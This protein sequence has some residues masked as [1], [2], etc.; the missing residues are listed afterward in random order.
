MKTFLTF[1]IVALGLELLVPI[2]LMAQTRTPWQM[3]YGAPLQYLGFESASYGDSTEYIFESIPPAQDSGWGPA[4][5][6]DVIKLKEISAECFIVD[7]IYHC[8]KVVDYTY[9]QTFVSYPSNM[10]LTKFTIRLYGLDD[11]CRVSVYNS[12]Y[13]NGYAIPGTFVKLGDGGNKFSLLAYANPC[14]ENRFVITHVDDCCGGVVLDTAFIDIAGQFIPSNIL[15]LTSTPAFCSSQDSSGTATVTS[16]AQGPF[17]YLW[18]TNPPQTTATA[19]NL[20]AG[21]YTCTV[22]PAVGCATIGSVVVGQ[23]PSAT[24]SLAQPSVSQINTCSYGRTAHIILGYP[25]AAQQLTMSA[26]IN[27]GSPPFTY[28]WSGDGSQYLSSKTIFN[29]K[30]NPAIQ[31]P[32]CSTYNLVLKVMDSKGCF[33]MDTVE[34]RVVRGNGA[35]ANC[36]RQ[37][38]KKILI[39]HVPPGNTGNPQTISIS[40]NAL[41]AHTFG[42]ALGPNPTSEAHKSDCIGTCGNQCSAASRL[43]AFSDV[44]NEQIYP[45][46]EEALSFELF[47]NPNQGVFKLNFNAVVN[48]GIKI[49]IYNLQGELLES[50]TRQQANEGSK[51]F[52][53]KLNT[54]KIPQG[55]YMLE[56]QLENGQRLLKKLSI[57]QE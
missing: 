4:P 41:S 12:T 46:E 25:G 48:S 34:I 55:I 39:C 14:E 22:T 51:S 26:T 31:V 7:P 17:T 16:T 47:P 19:I 40:T 6:P 2:N 45:L 23:A 11:G 32:E 57:V 36:N 33:A 27:G 1:F 28:L 20:P 56:A 53:L 50:Q 30:F 42:P 5:D 52:D 3:H 37:Q 21:T 44:A 43:S 13:P 49:S 35:L 8:R 54:T 18:N 29:P 9:F 15:T 38:N 24:V 10:Q